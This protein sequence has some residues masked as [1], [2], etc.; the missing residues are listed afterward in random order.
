MVEG[1]PI[2]PYSHSGQST[3]QFG[4]QSLSA[5]KTGHGF[6]AAERSAFKLRRT[7]NASQLRREGLSLE[8]PAFK[9]Q[10]ESNP[11]FFGNSLESNTINKEPSLAAGQG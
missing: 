6:E 3:C 2:Q 7:Y 8:K 10:T 4:D 11:T 5:E 9:Q 1:L